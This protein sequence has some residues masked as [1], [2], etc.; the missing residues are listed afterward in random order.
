[1][2]TLN[3]DR[4]LQ[5]I[6][7]FN[8]V[9]EMPGF[10]VD[11]DPNAVKLDTIIGNYTESDFVRCGLSN[12]HTKHGKGYLV[13][14]EDGTVTNIGK[15]CGKTHFGV[16]FE[17]MRQSFDRDIMNKER[18]ENLKA[19]Q[20]Q[21]PGFREI[22]AEVR[23]EK[24]GA[25]WV[26]KTIQELTNPGKGVPDSIVEVMRKVRHTRNPT[27]TKPRFAT[28][29]EVR[30]VEVAERRK[31]EGP[32]YI[33][34]PVGSIEGIGALYPENDIREL[35]ILGLEKLLKDIEALDVDSL[36]SPKLRANIN[37]VTSADAQLSRARASVNAGRIFLRADNLKVLMEFAEEE[38]EQGE[39]QKFLN[40]LDL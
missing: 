18:R 37:L 34:E 9:Y 39:F 3:T 40:S 19:F 30:Q 12:C 36:P 10:C 17:S 22:I 31:I 4:G 26:Y 23:G 8:D 33:D 7:N 24:A 5:R 11:F 13:K 25:D 2:I 20:N 21:I 1:M 14:V 16:D 27:L 15:D 6:E 29:A 32:Y 38:N 28:K 35:L